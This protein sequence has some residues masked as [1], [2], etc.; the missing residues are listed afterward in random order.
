MDM[1][2]NNFPIWECITGGDA[3][4]GN[5]ASAPVKRAKIGKLFLTMSYDADYFN[6]G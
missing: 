2:R 5:A 6:N 4:E 3:R 1:V